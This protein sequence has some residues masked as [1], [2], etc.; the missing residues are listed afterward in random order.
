MFRKSF[1]CALLGL[2]C[3]NAW[4]QSGSTTVGEGQSVSP[5]PSLL[6]EQERNT[7][8]PADQD[9]LQSMR[10][11]LGLTAPPAFP[12]NG[13]F[14]RPR[15]RESSNESSN[16]NPSNHPQDSAN[17]AAR[18]EKIA[19]FTS[20]EEVE[21]AC[22]V[23]HAQLDRPRLRSEKINLAHYTDVFT[24]PQLKSECTNIKDTGVIDPSTCRVEQDDCA[25]E[26]EDIFGNSYCVPGWTNRCTNVKICDTYANYKSTMECDLQV[27]LKLPNFIEQPLSQFVDGSYELIEATRKQVAT[28]LPLACAPADAQASRGEEIT[29]AILNR[30][31]GTIQ[32]RIRAAIEKEA[33][34]WVIETGVKTI[35]AA[36]PSGGIGGAAMMTTSLASFVRRAHKAVEPIIKIGN[37]V[38]DTAEDLGFSTSCGWSPWH[39]W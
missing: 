5:N 25:T 37:E 39:Q 27:Q 21:K 30:I 29:Q 23:L 35:V 38:K 33:K 11:S 9:Y 20:P 17:K 34:E 14:I 8:S 1:F 12:K 4:A 3:V 28:A 6:T 10:R 32:R 13:D 31:S 16:D 19:G 26:L 24:P 18:S 2:G 22:Q 15:R 7:L 36:I